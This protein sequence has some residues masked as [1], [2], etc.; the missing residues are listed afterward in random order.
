LTF[1]NIAVHQKH[2]EELAAQLP[3]RQDYSLKVFRGGDTIRKLICKDDKIVMPKTLQRRCVEW[4]H[5]NLCH[6]GET[7]TEATIRQHFYWPKLRNHV[8]DVC[9]KCDTCQ[10]TKKHRKKLGQLPAKQ[11]EASPWEVSCVDLIGPYKMNA[12]IESP[13]SCGV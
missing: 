11:T 10:R 3:L 2:D 8:V 9:K 6:P 13:C 5:D 7:R 12:K 1:R 4:Y